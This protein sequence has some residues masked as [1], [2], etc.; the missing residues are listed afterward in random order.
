[1]KKNVTYFMILSITVISL[2]YC[3]ILEALLPKGLIVPSAF[4]SVGHIAHLN[5]RDEHLP[6]KKLIAKVHHHSR[7][8]PSLIAV[9]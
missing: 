7:L 1:M 6:Y 8:F 9:R 4:E 2:I 3:Q 5:L